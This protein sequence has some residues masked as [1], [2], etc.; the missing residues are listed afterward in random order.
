MK[1]GINSIVFHKNGTFLELNT[2]LNEFWIQLSPT[3]GYAKFVCVVESSVK[4]FELKEIQPMSDIAPSP[5]VALPIVLMK[6]K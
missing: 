1:L 6:K 4:T 5:L 2:D 3:I